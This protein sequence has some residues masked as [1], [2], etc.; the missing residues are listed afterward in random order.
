MT[1]PLM[2]MCPLCGDFDPQDRFAIHDVAR[3]ASGVTYGRVLACTRCDPM[4][5]RCAEL[6]S[7]RLARS[8]PAVV[9]AQYLRVE[10]FNRDNFDQSIDPV[11]AAV[12][13]FIAHARPN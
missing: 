9:L 10:I 7:A 11:A 2:L 5:T 1:E 8:V 6:A 13:A 4:L 12:E 3:T